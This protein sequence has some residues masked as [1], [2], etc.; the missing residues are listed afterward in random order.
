MTKERYIVYG[1]Y[2]HDATG[3]DDQVTVDAVDALGP[4]SAVARIR[5]ARGPNWYDN[6]AAPLSSVLG[7]LQSLAKVHPEQIEE[8][9]IN[10]A[11]SCRELVDCD[12]CGA[13]HPDDFD[14]D[15]RDDANR[16]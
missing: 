2:C 7:N 8:D 16:F 4:D 13:R 6:D 3:D 11:E 14:G 5:A 10:L 9:I 1:F 12:G 15:C